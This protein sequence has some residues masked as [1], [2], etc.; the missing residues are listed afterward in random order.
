MEKAQE[1]GWRR[2]LQHT[3]VHKNE[4]SQ[5][6]DIGGGGSVEPMSLSPREVKLHNA[7]PFEKQN[8]SLTVR[9]TTCISSLY[10]QHQY[11]RV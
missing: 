10:F 9:D 5:L 3:L 8:L 7:A 6:I 2:L 4:D 1:P 11:N